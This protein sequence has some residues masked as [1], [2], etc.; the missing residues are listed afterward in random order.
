MVGRRGTLQ[1]IRTSA[2]RSVQYKTV[3]GLEFVSRW[4]VPSWFSAN[5]NRFPEPWV[6]KPTMKIKMDR[7][8]RGRMSGY[9]LGN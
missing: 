2:K 4:L 3:L 9:R 1:K 8:G 7:V 5:R 6:M